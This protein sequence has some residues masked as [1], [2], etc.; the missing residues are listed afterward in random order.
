MSKEE[1]F[2]RAEDREQCLQ[3]W[4]AGE[5]IR[6]TP[7]H[8][9]HGVFIAILLAGLRTF[10]KQGQGG[11]AWAEVLVDFGERTCGADLAVLFTEHLDR[12]VDGRLRGTPDII[13]EVLSADSVERDRVEKFNA[14][15]GLGVPW[16]WIGDP[17][18]GLLEEYHRSAEGYVRSS[19]GTLDM[20][21]KPRALPGFSQALID[22]M[23]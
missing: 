13:V 17:M 23:D 1:F 8:S 15:F 21:F 20:D 10:L 3:D 7:A 5:A 6:V 12:H 18:S 11:N 19:S 2:R 9:R 22:L 4:E 14:Y 16:Y